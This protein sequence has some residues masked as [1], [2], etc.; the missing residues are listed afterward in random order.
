MGFI[1]LLAVTTFA[2]ASAAAF[3]SIYGLAQIFAGAFWPVVIMASTLEVGKLVAASYLY[4]FWSDISK[5]MRYYLMSAVAVLMLIT[6]A[7]IFGFLASA[8][9]S[10]SLNYAQVQTQV[11]LLEEQKAQAERL[12]EERLARRNQIDAEV[13]NLPSNVVRG[14]QRLI[15]TYAEERKRIEADVQKYTTEIEQKTKEIADLKMKK[16]E[17]EAHV[18]PILYIAEALGRDTNTA[19]IWM[20]YLIMFAF[21]PLA[22]ALTIAVNNALRKRKEENEGKADKEEVVDEPVDEPEPHVTS[23]EQLLVEEPIERIVEVPSV[24]PEAEQAIK[25]MQKRKLI[26]EQIRNPK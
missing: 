19:I 18:G 6:S 1:I 3:F 5:V 26:R 22:V 16:L 21:D 2:I 23:V 17:Q 4:R 15:N 12:K 20:I 9:Q 14:R 24:S 10:G 25:E 7:G 13:A 8:H 11:T